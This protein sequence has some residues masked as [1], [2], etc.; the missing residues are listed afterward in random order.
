[1]TEKT[2]NA[3]AAGWVYVFICE[4]SS[5]E[6]YLGLY[7][8]EKDTNFIPAFRTK[9]DANDCYLELPREKGKK[10]ELQAVHIEELTETAEKNGFVIAIV[11]GDGKIVK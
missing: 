7:D 5:E 3:L 2:V 6:S 1:M 4:P 8:E 9:E 10:Y 11:D